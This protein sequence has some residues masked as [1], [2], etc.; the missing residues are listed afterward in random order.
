[1]VEEAKK[2]KKENDKAKKRREAELEVIRR[3]RGDVEEAEVDPNDP[4]EK[5]VAELEAEAS[6][7]SRRSRKEGKKRT[8]CV[9]QEVGQDKAVEKP[10]RSKCVIEEVNAPVA[11]TPQMPES[12]PD[13]PESGNSRRTKSRKDREARLKAAMAAVEADRAN[14]ED[15]STK[16]N[17]LSDAEVVSQLEAESRSV[18]QDED[19]EIIVEEVKETKKDGLGGLQGDGSTWGTKLEKISNMDAKLEDGAA[20]TSLSPDMTALLDVEELD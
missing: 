13:A 19:A 3:T 14:P 15:A 11:E 2:E 10:R 6:S 16:F 18:P 5:L 4:Q 9:I 8:K 17:Q 12:A 20:A 1:M 7:T